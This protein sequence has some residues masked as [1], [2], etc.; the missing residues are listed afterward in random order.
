MIEQRNR[1]GSGRP[2]EGRPEDELRNPAGEA[3]VS[4]GAH[5]NAED[6]EHVVLTALGS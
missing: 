2:S 1:H 4:R 3:A 6:A 5:S